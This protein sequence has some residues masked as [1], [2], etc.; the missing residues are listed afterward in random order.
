MSDLDALADHL[1]RAEEYARAG[2]AA[3]AIA[4]LNSA[5]E[6]LA[7]NPVECP[8][9]ELGRE[10]AARLLTAAAFTE[11]RENPRTVI[12][13]RAGGIGCDWDLADALA[14]LPDAKLVGWTTGML[15]HDLGVVTADDRSILFDVKRPERALY[16]LRMGRA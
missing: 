12:H 9:L 11:E 10:E 8:D 2:A 5:L 13:S 16:A 15:G 1:S 4:Q 3:D 6:V 7:P 14:L